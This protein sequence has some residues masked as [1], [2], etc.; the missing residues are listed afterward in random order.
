MILKRFGE[1]RSVFLFPFDGFYSRRLLGIL[2]AAFLRPCFFRKG[3]LLPLLPPSFTGLMISAVPYFA[4]CSLLC[5]FL[6][7]SS[8]WDV[9]RLLLYFP[10]GP[11]CFYQRHCLLALFYSPLSLILLILSPWDV[12]HI[13]L[14]FCLYPLCFY[15]RHCLLALFYSPPSLI[16]LILS[17]WDV[18]CPLLL[19]T[20]FS[21]PSSVCRPHSSATPLS[22]CAFSLS[23]NFV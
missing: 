5:L 11:L 15:Q 20:L 8:L 3:R 10:L 21:A 19:F 7:I 23:P 4:L 14:L 1:I 22:F 18:S 17:P 16:L 9:S 2:Y 6:F 13:L 12:S